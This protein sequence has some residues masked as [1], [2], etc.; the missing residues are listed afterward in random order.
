MRLEQ[1]VESVQWAIDT[2]GP[3]MG[4]NKARISTNIGNYSSGA[5]MTESVFQ[6]AV[7]KGLAQATN[8]KGDKPL[9]K[10]LWGPSDL[11][12]STDHL[13][14]IPVKTSKITRVWKGEEI[15]KEYDLAW[16][17]T[18]SKLPKW[19]CQIKTHASTHVKCSQALG[20]MFW[21]YVDKKYLKNRH[22]REVEMVFIWSEYSG[23]SGAGCRADDKF[24]HF[25]Q[26]DGKMQFRVEPGYSE[27]DYKNNGKV[28]RLGNVSYINYKD[29]R[30]NPATWWWDR[31]SAILAPN[32][33]TA[34]KQ[35]L[36][37]GTNSSYYRMYR[38]KGCLIIN[39]NYKQIISQCG[40]WHAYIHHIKGGR[41]TRADGKKL[42]EWI[43]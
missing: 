8:S 10:K 20:D 1:L 2:Y 35:I 12:N 31:E 37:S 25:V 27:Y 42:F 16:T 23:Q 34:I 7:C 33:I 30:N 32:N 24:L 17:C 21:A 5:E 40:N 38:Q 19:Y 36:G 43:P 41:L 9:I 29:Q 6:A 4:K 14:E 18:N 39:T 22:N 15:Q 3:H 11:W 26:N 28:I 13:P